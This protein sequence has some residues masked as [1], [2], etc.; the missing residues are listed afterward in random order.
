MRHKAKFIL[1]PMLFLVAIAALSAVVML[2]WNAIVPALFTSVP[3]INYLQALGLLVL[4]RILFGG[5][6][7]HGGWRGRMHGHRH[8]TWTRALGEVAGDDAGRARTISPPRA[9]MTMTTPF[10]Q[11]CAYLVWVTRGTSARVLLYPSRNLKM[12]TAGAAS[13]CNETIGITAGVDPTTRLR[14]GATD[15][16]APR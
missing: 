14:P 5:L 4:C 12:D 1:W 9:A 10:R 16:E 2:L 6:R 11:P 8:A 15:A 3:A 7:G 13:D